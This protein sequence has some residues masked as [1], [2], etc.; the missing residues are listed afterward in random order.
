MR[1]LAQI[2]IYLVSLLTVLLLA[3]TTW[4]ATLIGMNAVTLFPL[5]FFG[6][7]VIGML[8][9]GARCIRRSNSGT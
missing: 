7:V 4:H 2:A 1:V 8:L 3:F 9:F 5:Y 6:I